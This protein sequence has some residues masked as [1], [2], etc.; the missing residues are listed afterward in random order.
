MVDF[1]KCSQTG[2]VLCGPWGIAA[3][4]P[5][6]QTQLHLEVTFQRRESSCDLVMKRHKLWPGMAMLV[7]HG[8]DKNN[9]I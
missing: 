6:M 7:W 5:A 9:F 3:I 4:P 2:G 1:S 8:G